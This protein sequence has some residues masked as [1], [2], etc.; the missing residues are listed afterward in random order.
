[1]QTKNKQTYKH[2]FGD[3]NNKE[4]SIEY[5]WKKT[6]SVFVV[7]GKVFAQLYDELPF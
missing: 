6:V 7:G 4:M 1:M 5:F 2:C 3:M